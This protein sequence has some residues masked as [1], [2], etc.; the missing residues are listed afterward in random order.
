[1]AQGY[2]NGTLLNILP[3]DEEIIKSLKTIGILN[4]KGK[5]IFYNCVVFPLYDAKGAIVNLYGRNID[6][7]CEIKHLYLP[8]KRSGLV[9]RA[10]A[11]RSQTLLLTESII[12]ALTL[13]DQGFK[14]VMPLYGVN[15]LIDDHLFFFNRKIKEA[16]LVFDADDAGRKAAQAVS[17]QLKEKEIIPHIVDLPVKDVNVYFKRHTPEEFE[18]LLKT[19]QPQVPGTVGQDQQP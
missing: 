5:E 18:T 8:G 16:Y 13:Y 3:D 2:A 11:I 9:N 10:A 19:G 17:L 14:N 6:D 7:D 1:M 15:G 4:G 12:D